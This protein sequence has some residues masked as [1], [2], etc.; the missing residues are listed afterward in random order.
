MTNGSLAADPSY[1]GYQEAI[2]QNG[3]KGALHHTFDFFPNMKAEQKT[4]WTN[5]AFLGGI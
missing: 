3:L 5:T 1:V 4:F 2:E